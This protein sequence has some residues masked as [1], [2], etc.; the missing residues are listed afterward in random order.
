MRSKYL[1]PQHHN[2]DTLQK[3]M[4]YRIRKESESNMDYKV[5]EKESKIETEKQPSLVSVCI[6]TKNEKEKLEKCLKSFMC[7]GYDIVVVDTGSTDGTR[8]MVKNYTPYLYDFEWVNDFSAARNFA[9]SKVKSEYIIMADSDETLKEW[10]KKTFE[11]RMKA[12]PKGLGCIREENLLGEDGKDCAIYD[13]PRV[14]SK[15]YY[16][17]EG[18]IHEQVVPL[19]EE[20]QKGEYYHSGLCFIHT[21][22]IGTP[23]EKARKIKRNIDLLELELEKNPEDVYIWFQIGKGYYMAKDYENACKYFG[24]ALEFDV[25]ETLDYVQDLVESYGYSLVNA[26]QYDTAYALLQVTYEAFART[27]DYHFLAGLIYMQN[28]MFEDAVNEFLLAT[29]NEKVCVVG[30]NSYKA[31]YNIGVIYECLGDKKN[32]R[33]YYEK[34]GSYD[35]AIKRLKEVLA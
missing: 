16:H 2:I 1:C 35:L 7:T 32:A 30:A 13:E 29:K 26:K 19:S 15:R 34:C 33:L 23:E 14:F 22:Y 6:I 17:Y 21:G 27:A 20:I 18:S 8:E 9:I 10:D 25:D 11:S 31:Y 3:E 5:S 4:E 28:A 24:K 12:H